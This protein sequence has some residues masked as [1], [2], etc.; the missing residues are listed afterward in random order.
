MEP[1][2]RKRLVEFFAS[3]NEEIYKCLGKDL[4]WNE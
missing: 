3:Y 2:L 4:G 1:N